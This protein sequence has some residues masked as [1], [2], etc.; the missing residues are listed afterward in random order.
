M[1]CNHSE[2]RNLSESLNIIHEV[3]PPQDEFYGSREDYLSDFDE[4]YPC[5][6][7]S[8]NFDLHVNLMKTLCTYTPMG[9]N[10]QAIR[11]EAKKIKWVY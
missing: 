10:I 5:F 2:C 11:H 3:Y 8:E 1:S 6:Q 7:T 4:V 9:I